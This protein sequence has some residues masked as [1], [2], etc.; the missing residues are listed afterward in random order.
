MRLVTWN[1]AHRADTRSQAEFLRGLSPDVVALQEV[2]RTSLRRW[3]PLL[4]EIGLSHWMSPVRDPMRAYSGVLIASK[5]PLRLLSH[6]DGAM[7]TESRWPNMHASL[8]VQLANGIRLHTA[9]LWGE[10]PDR[11]EVIHSAMSR[12]GEHPT[13]LAGDLRGDE[14]DDPLALRKF[15]MR[16]VCLDLHGH[17]EAGCSFVAGMRSDHVFASCDLRVR[18]ATYWT[19]KMGTI[20]EGGL[21]DHAP[22]EVEF[23]L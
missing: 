15:G 11:R 18:R 8:S 10:I 23:D 13:I 12:R 20:A 5:A 6:A 21:S 9:C 17:D 4:K 7:D 1:T 2:I 22:L 3:K 19:G 14:S 16:D